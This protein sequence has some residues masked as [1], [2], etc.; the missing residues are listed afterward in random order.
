[1][2]SAIAGLVAALA[3]TGCVAVPVAEPGPAHGY[4]YAPP[5]TVFFGF[6]GGHYRHHYR[7]DRHYQRG[8]RHHHRH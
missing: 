4:Y 7:G 5:P 1:M 3:L 2:K 6:H 8:H